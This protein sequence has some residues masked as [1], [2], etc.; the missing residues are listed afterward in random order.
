MIELLAF[1]LLASG[2]SPSSTLSE[3]AHA[4]EADRIVQARRMIADAIAAGERGPEIDRF[5]ADLAFAEKRW[6]EAQARYADLF[7]LNRRIHAVPSGLGLQV[8]LPVTSEMLAGS[9]KKRLPWAVL[10]GGCGMR[11]VSCATSRPIGTARMQ[12]T[13]ALWSWCPTSLKSSTITAGHS[14][15]AGNGRVQSSRS[16]GQPRPTRS[17]PGSKTISSSYVLPFRL[18]CR[19]VTVAKAALILLHV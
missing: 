18:T 5:L 12:L 13:G 14:F 1:A 10:P 8:S 2:D 15:F 16:R 19:D 7:A 9:S 17:R 11:L 4:L 3:A 6:A